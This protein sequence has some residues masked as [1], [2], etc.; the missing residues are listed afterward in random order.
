VGQLQ[1]H[2]GLA[3][4]REPLVWER[5][6]EKE[7]TEKGGELTEGLQQS[8]KAEKESLK[9]AGNHLGLFLNGAGGIGSRE[10]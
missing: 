10:V 7:I 2:R 6:K 4:H 9:T 3:Y 5:R 1:A 8:L